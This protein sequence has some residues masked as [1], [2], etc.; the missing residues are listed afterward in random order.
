MY[1]LYT[2]T[3][4][5]ILVHCCISTLGSSRGCAGGETETLPE[6]LRSPTYTGAIGDQ[7]SLV[8]LA[9]QSSQGDVWQ[10]SIVFVEKKR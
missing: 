4:R 10:L 9:Q 7:D 5:H 6:K 3:C 8:L 1:I 2:Y